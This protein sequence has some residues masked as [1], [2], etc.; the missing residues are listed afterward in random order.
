MFIV[1]YKSSELEYSNMKYGSRDQIEEALIELEKIAENQLRQ[2]AALKAA[3]GAGQGP[4]GAQTPTEPR[5]A[6]Q[7]GA[8]S[9]ELQSQATE[10]L[11]SVATSISQEDLSQGY[12]QEQLDKLRESKGLT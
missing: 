8:P 9:A 3:E 11:N 5:F 2:Q 1:L 4:G 6:A 10:Y 7:V 12:N